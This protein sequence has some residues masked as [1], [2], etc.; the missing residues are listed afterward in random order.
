MEQS[1]GR[2]REK[3][4]DLRTSP[5][6]H[7]H[8]E[9]SSVPRASYP[10]FPR[11]GSSKAGGKLGH[12]QATVMVTVQTRHWATRPAGRIQRCRRLLGYGTAKQSD[13]STPKSCWG[14]EQGIAISQFSSFTNFY[15]SKDLNL[16]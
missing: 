4:K 16:F 9:L 15:L 6:K 10:S 7:R 14:N 11:L 3:M 5:A 1:T 2:R 8:T 12:R 13:G